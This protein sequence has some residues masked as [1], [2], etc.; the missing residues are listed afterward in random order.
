MLKGLNS[1]NKKSYF[2]LILSVVFIF[3]MFF[4]GLIVQSNY[5][6]SNIINVNADDYF[7]GGE[8]TELNPLQIA[9]K[10]QLYNLA[11]LIN[12]PVTNSTYRS[13][14]Y[15]L[16]EDI[17]FASDESEQWIPIGKDSAN[18]YFAGNFDGNGHTITNLTI[19]E[20]ISGFEN[21]G[22]FGYVLGTSSVPA[23]ISN[24]GFV[25]TNINIS[26]SATIYL[27]AVAGQAYSYVDILNCYNTGN[28]SVTSSAIIYAGGITGRT[29][30]SNQIT[31]C[32]NTANI[33]GSS[34]TST[35]NIG[36]IT[37]R[38][39]SSNQIANCYNTGNI[40]TT[41]SS[42]SY[43]GGIAGSFYSSSIE[44]LDC[45]NTGNINVTSSSSSVTGG[46]V[47]YV[48]SSYTVEITNSYNIGYVTA[49]ASSV[50]KGGIVGSS[51][52][53]TKI[54]YCYALI[55]Q[56]YTALYNGSIS[57][58]TGAIKT[59]VDMINIGT[60]ANWDI[61]GETSTWIMTGALP[62]LRGLTR[63][64]DIYYNLILDYNSELTNLVSFY[65]AG[66]QVTLP[67]QTTFT[68]FLSG[69]ALTE[70]GEVVYNVNYIYTMPSE[71]ITLYAQWEGY[72]E[73]GE[74]TEI[75]P[76]QIATKE[77]LYNLANLVNNSAAT[78]TTYKSLY[79]ELIADITFASDGSEQWKPIGSTTS[80]YFS[81]KFNGNGHIITN[82]TNTSYIT[83]YSYYG[84]FGYVRGI[85]TSNRAEIKNIGLV[86]TRIDFYSG[87]SIYAGSVAGRIEYYTNI[88][89]CYNTGEII[90]KG[91][92]SY[93]GGIVGYSYSDTQII[94]C[95]NTGSVGVIN[96]STSVYAGGIVGYS[97]TLNQITNSYNIGYITSESIKGGIM[98][99]SYS[100]D[101]E[102][103][104]C[105]ALENQGYTAVYGSGTAPTINT[106]VIVTLEEMM[107]IETY[108]NWDFEGETSVWI[109]AAL[110]Y[111][112]GITRIEDIYR[113]LTYNYNYPGLDDLVELHT[114][115]SNIVLPHGIR[116]ID[117]GTGYIIGWAE[118]EF[119]EVVY[120]AG[121]TYIM[122]NENST[123]YAQWIEITL[124]AGGNGTEATP[125]QIANKDQL[126]YLSI[127]INDSITNSIY[128]SLYY[129]LITHITFTDDESEQWIPIGKNDSLYFMGHFNGNNHTI[130]N[131][132]I[133]SYK[134]DFNYYG[135]FGYVKGSDTPAE[136]KNI[137]FIDT[138]INVANA[139][140]L[141]SGSVAGRI[142][143]TNVS[144]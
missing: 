135:L 41:I 33:T 117:L 40:V 90:L 143:D 19:T 49:I 48:Y 68:H 25:D 111:L 57:T 82:L 129:E 65:K 7:E 114:V 95:Y 109:M 13:L 116:H 21:Y 39:Y 8:G 94:N 127:L 34:A 30:S 3:S 136:I 61:I 103:N 15:D 26:S 63:T 89:N 142:E 47:G 133:T 31:N 87:N 43:A 66:E 144:N 106:R 122:P 69:W 16:M 131:L 72:F 102:I 10:E 67:N 134:T 132:T 55:N 112:R 71:N 123:L 85:N 99:G 73:S 141:F 125:F 29:Y 80:W 24:L 45:Y 14:Y 96:S 91:S 105:Y 36:G 97:R 18:L 11:N 53:G 104:N 64:E 130:T 78:N 76:F 93:A 23:N 58:N 107:D 27:G 139:S 77:Q 62:T 126:H 75:N 1:E 17:T 81:G 140:D 115:N 138:N 137:G 113:T 12:D 46:I 5:F 32:Y 79:Y 9:T 54:N 60:Y 38:L 86:G 44:I 52:T 120:D 100:S 70:I 2:H 119:G 74:G 101:N 6:N 35:V 4:I 110:P 22:L 108:V 56:G 121:D 51:G 84:L 50:Y 83:G 128:R 88:S 124:F 42:S 37:G 28:I 92:Y 59:A 98:G 118:E 20:Y